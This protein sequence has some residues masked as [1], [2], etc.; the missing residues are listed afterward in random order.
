MKA[1]TISRVGTIDR[2]G[3]QETGNC[4]I[5][6]IESALCEAMTRFEKEYMGRRPHRVQ[7]HLLGDMVVVRL[8]GALTVAE[9]K[10]ADGS[11]TAKGVPLVKQMRGTLVETNRPIMEAI[12]E[13]LVS[14]AV[15]S[16]H[17]DISTV[18]GEEVL[19]FTLG[20][21]C[22][23]DPAGSR[24]TSGQEKAGNRRLDE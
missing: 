22:S 2:F 6:E 20:K 21:H 14:A 23:P 1:R 16:L 18:T 13:K 4:A 17:H 5:K 11:A 9:K 15:Q 12:V 3:A 7:T 8:Q 19:V 10:L 24:Q